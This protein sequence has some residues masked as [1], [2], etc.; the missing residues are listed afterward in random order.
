MTPLPP[1]L[2]AYVDRLRRCPT[3]GEWLSE[4]AISD[5]CTRNHDRPKGN[6]R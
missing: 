5:K 4:P 1:A 6:L 3:C 2:R